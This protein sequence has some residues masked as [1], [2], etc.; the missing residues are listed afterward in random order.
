MRSWSRLVSSLALV[1]TCAASP[2]ALSATEMIMTNE[3]AT[4][5]FKT[6]D[7]EA[8]ARDVERRSGGA[9]TVKVYPAGQLY[10]DRDAMAAL[11]T[12]SVHMAWPVSVN[13]E[14]LDPRAGIATLPF[15]LDDE[16]MLKPG[17][18]QDFAKL[19]S[20]YVEPRGVQVLA[21]LR[22]ADALF[23]FKDLDVRSL[24]DVKGKK[25]RVTGG[26]I[27]LDIFR[28]FGASPVSLPASEMSS[29]LASGAIDGIYTSPSGWSQI[30]GITARH[31]S[32][33]PGLSLL[34]YSVVVDKKWL[35]ALPPAQKQAVIDAT[36]ALAERQ[37][38]EAI[39][40]DKT[41]I[42]LMTSQGATYWVADPAET[43][44]WKAA[45]AP[46][47]KTFTDKYKD[48]SAAY[49]ALVKKHGG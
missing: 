18:A 27:L 5:H 48:V 25:I 1:V 38:K 26:R 32:V 7:M 21:L 3:V 49:E 11:G 22:T 15:T 41:E 19:L 12:G 13:L 10:N 2:T 20:S 17:F 24:A 44:K 34:T 40:Q 46:A 8:F 9:I 31:G 16:L 4:T 39:A 43:A 36:N 30:V 45:A 6:K 42:K 28:N 23:I 47:I 33:I 14:P 29:A 37:W 35:D